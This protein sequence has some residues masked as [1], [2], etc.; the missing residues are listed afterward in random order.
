VAGVLLD[1]VEQD[2]LEG[3]RVGA[4]PAF[5]GL[6]HLVEVVG[7]DDE[8]AAFGLV[9]QAGQQRGR[10]FPVGDGPAIAVAVGPWVTDVA[11]F[12]APLEPAPFDVA[13][14]L[15]QLKGGPAGRQAGAPPLGGGQRFE[16]G[17]EPGTEI[18]EVAEED[19]GARV[20]RD[21]R[22]EKRLGHAAPFLTASQAIIP[23]A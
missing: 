17:G 7:G 11:A 6:A 22:R 23:R 10:G 4:V 3:G 18:A 20:H 14:V 9:A 13:Q 12:E 16:L 15:E 19:L 2:P 5:T 1:Q 8:A 21:R